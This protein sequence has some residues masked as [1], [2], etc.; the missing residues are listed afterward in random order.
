MWPYVWPSSINNILKAAHYGMKFLQYYSHIKAIVS[1]L[2]NPNKLHLEKLEN[3][4]QIGKKI[5][6][7]KYVFHLEQL[8]SPFFHNR[9]AQR[10]LVCFVNMYIYIA[11][12]TKIGH[13]FRK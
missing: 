2:I 5:Y 11:R 6:L 3:I 13:N 7:E 10:K 4:F 8:F 12:L 1:Y 9:H